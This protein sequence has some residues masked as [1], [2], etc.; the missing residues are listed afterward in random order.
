MNLESKLPKLPNTS[1]EYTAF[2]EKILILEDLIR[3]GNYDRARLLR[4]ELRPLIESTDVEHYTLSAYCRIL[5][6]KLLMVDRDHDAAYSILQDIYPARLKDHIYV[7]FQYNTAFGLYYM[8]I[9]EH[10][11][12]VDYFEKSLPLMKQLGVK[13]VP[14][15]HNLAACYTEIDR[16]IKAIVCFET[17]QDM[18]VKQN[19]YL[20][21]NMYDIDIAVNYTNLMQYKEAEGILKN[22]LSSAT[23]AFS[24]IHIAMAHQALGCVYRDTK[25]FDKA[26]EQFDKA[27]SFF[28]K[29]SREYRSNLLD[30]SH[31]L[32]DA[33]RHSEANECIEYGLSIYKA[34]FIK[35]DDL[36]LLFQANAHVLNFP[37]QSSLN[38]IKKMTIPVLL[39]QRKLLMGIRYCQFL[40][41]FYIS[42]NDTKNALT[43]SE[44]SNA[45]HK[46]FLSGG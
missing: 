34:N 10:A 22:A 5:N 13:N 29:D 35:R 32:I 38:F 19:S 4:D 20:A 3:E 45:F 1:G 28:S 2:K 37:D 16:P 24:S 15:Y 23:S 6:A 43:F 36:H 9:H 33:G 46:R 27:A 7:L 14:I 40:V 25:K 18:A 8:Y 31:T 17:T 21:N 11:K 12:A 39:E 41:N 30:K 44:K 42:V 26:I